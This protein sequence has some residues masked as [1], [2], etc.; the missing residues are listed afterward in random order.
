MSDGFPTTPIFDALVAEA[1]ADGVVIDVP[2][3]FTEPDRTDLGD[4]ENS[5][6]YVLQHQ[7]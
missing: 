4:G 3:V 6:T 5:R 1:K 7:E 2:L